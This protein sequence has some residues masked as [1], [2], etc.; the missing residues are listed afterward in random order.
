MTTHELQQLRPGDRVRWLDGNDP[1][2]GAV[3]AISTTHVSVLWDSGETTNFA[4][5]NGVPLMGRE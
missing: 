4:T 5:V 2:T 1:D 3:T